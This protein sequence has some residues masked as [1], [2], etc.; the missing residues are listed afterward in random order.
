MPNQFKI[1][2]LLDINCVCG[3][4]LKIGYDE[5]NHPCIIHSLPTCEQFDTCE[6][7][8]ELLR[9]INKING[10]SIIP[11]SHQQ[12]TPRNVPSCVS[13]PHGNARWGMN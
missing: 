6:N 1:N 11:K 9:H 12:S 5:E 4:R 13:E 3:E 2:V 8:A 7:P 10:S